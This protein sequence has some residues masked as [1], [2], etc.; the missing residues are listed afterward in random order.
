MD[1]S[2]GIIKVMDSHWYLSR[3]CRAAPVQGRTRYSIAGSFLFAWRICWFGISSPAWAPPAPC[4]GP[5]SQGRTG[6][7]TLFTHQIWPFLCKCVWWHQS[8]PDITGLSR[9]PHFV[10]VRLVLSSLTRYQNTAKTLRFWKYFWALSF[11]VF[12]ATI[13]WSKHIPLISGALVL[14]RERD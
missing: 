12:P 1:R 13:L 9:P 8:A 14:I 3:T 4:P 5:S 6:N 7:K 11:L 2:V 10:N